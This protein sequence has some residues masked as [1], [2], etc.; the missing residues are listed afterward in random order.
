[1]FGDIAVSRGTTDELV[2]LPN[3]KELHFNAGWT[4][5]CHKENGA[6]KIFRVEATLNPVNNVFVSYQLAKAKTIFAIGGFLAGAVLVTIVQLLRRKP[7]T[8]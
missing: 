3:G 4:S 2:R 5:V 7:K 8:T 6:W 1:L